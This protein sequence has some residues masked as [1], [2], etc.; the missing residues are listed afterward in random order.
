MTPSLHR[1]STWIFSGEPLT[2][3]DD[4][5]GNVAPVV[6]GPVG[7]IHLECRG[8]HLDIRVEGDVLDGEGDCLCLVEMRTEDTRSWSSHQEHVVNGV[9][10][11]SVGAAGI[12][13]SL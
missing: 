1:L 13:Q 2:R 6:G 4:T 11:M 10:L 12:F 7:D 8:G 3:H 9:M 5:E